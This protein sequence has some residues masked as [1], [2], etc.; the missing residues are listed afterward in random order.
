MGELFRETQL[1]HTDGYTLRAHLL[2]RPP[3]ARVLP[4]LTPTREEIAFHDAPR[5]RRLHLEHRGQ[6]HVPVRPALSL[7]RDAHREPRPVG[8]QFPARRN[9]KTG[10]R[11]NGPSLL[12]RFMLHQSDWSGARSD[13]VRFPSLGRRKILVRDAART[14]ALLPA[15]RR[16]CPSP[17]GLCNPFRLYDTAGNHQT[18][19]W[20]IAPAFPMKQKALF[21]LAAFIA[22]MSSSI[23][24]A[25]PTPA[26]RVAAIQTALRDAKLDGWLFYD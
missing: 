8:V 19:D 24:R 23:M 21:V 5:A 7:A 1:L 14:N 9:A 11:T 22:F 4:G 6:R 2:A 16:A 26:E 3:R 18:A 10:G 12:R 25:N 20:T 13:V 15:R 17:F